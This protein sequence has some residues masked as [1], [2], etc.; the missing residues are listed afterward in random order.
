MTTFMVPSR[1]Q[2]H[3]NALEQHRV[4]EAVLW[5]P[6]RRRDDADRSSHAGAE[7]DSQYNALR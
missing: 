3:Y 5:C 6:R 7:D 4:Q 2:G 1:V